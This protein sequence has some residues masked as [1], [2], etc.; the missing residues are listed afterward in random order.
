VLALRGDVY[1]PVDQT[2]REP[3]SDRYH[4]DDKGD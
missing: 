4:A 3:A 2:H 1:S